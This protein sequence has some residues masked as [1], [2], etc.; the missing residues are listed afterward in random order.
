MPEPTAAHE[1][2]FQVA[3]GDLADLERLLPLLADALMPVLSNR[4]R[5]HLRRCQTILSN[6]RWN[7]GPPRDVEVM[8]AGGEG[9]P[10]A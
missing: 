6:V 8:D 9:G 4:T 3:E 10:D 7:Y 1:R 2:L 5:V